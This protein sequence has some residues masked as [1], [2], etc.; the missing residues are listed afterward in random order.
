MVIVGLPLAG[1]G[2]LTTC[3]P[4]AEAVSVH[5]DTLVGGRVV[6][7][8]RDMSGLPQQPVP[9]LVED[10]RIGSVN[11]TCDAFG[12]VFSLAVD[13]DGRIYVADF[14]ANEIR[15][16]SA[17]GECL[18]TF[19]RS[20]EGPGEFTML[21]GILWRPP[22][23]LWAFDAIKGRFTVFDSLGT[24]VVTHRM[25]SPR[26]ASLPW[27]LWGDSRDRLH[28]WDPGPRN[29]IKYGPGLDLNPLDT[30]RVPRVEVDMYE[31]TYGDIR[32]M[33][34]IPHSPEIVWTVDWDGD[35]WLAN[36]SVFDL[37]ETT[38]TGDTLR[39]LQLRRPA[40]QLAGRERDS[41]ATAIGVPARTLPATKAVLGGISTS[42]N[43]WVWA[44][45]GDRPIVVWDVFDEQGHYL[46]P[47]TPPM[48]I[49][50]EPFPVFGA[51]TVTAVTEDDYGVQYVVRLRVTRPPSS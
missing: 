1:V 40:P 47:V 13:A 10:L 50:A 9:T 26:A 45:R 43:G 32:A 29:I 37:H 24:V 18:H 22:G 41:L 6:V 5:V 12:Q 30:L 14:R 3:G 21:A 42:P 19:G 46:G 39:S 20:G 48:P 7:S 27:R 51:G 16:F 8:N 31:Q 28:Y 11:G 23:V 49:A 35:V 2:A 15:V 25:V 36:T 44:E 4:S 17:D 33:S 38:Y 34:P